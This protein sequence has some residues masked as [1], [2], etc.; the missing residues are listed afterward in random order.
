M[1]RLQLTVIL[2]LGILGSFAFSKKPDPLANKKKVSWVTKKGAFN[3]IAC[4]HDLE[5]HKFSLRSTCSSRQGKSCWSAL[6]RRWSNRATND[7]DVDD[8]SIRFQN[9][10]KI[11]WQLGIFYVV[12]TV[13]AKYVKPFCSYSGTSIWRRAKELAKFVRCNEVSLYRGLFS[14]ILLLLG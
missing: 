7:V 14:Y 13:F 4:V 3:H 12:I 5:N 9:N 10:E 2:L 6:D 11:L 8:F 1:H